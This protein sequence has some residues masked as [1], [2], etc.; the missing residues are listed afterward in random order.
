MADPHIVS[1]GRNRF[2]GLRSD[3]KMFAPDLRDSVLGVV[4]ENADAATWEQLHEMAR[5]A[6]SFLEKE[7]LYQTLGTAR[8]PQLAQRALR[9]TLDDEIAVTLRPNLIKTVAES[10]YPDAAFE[11]V[12]AHLPQVN[13][14]LEPDSR[15]TFAARLLLHSGNAKMIAKL[16][17]YAE[18]NI[19]ADARKE[20]I[21]AEATIAYN[22]RV[23]S[24]QVSALD[25]WLP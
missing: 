2:T 12:S 18:Q 3:P 10:H 4:A 1:E 5:H 7:Q 17:S 14:W 11:F 15:N 9:L 20:A 23:R 19:P 25:R 8:D 21:V 13:E 6:G 22:E 16:R 24:Q